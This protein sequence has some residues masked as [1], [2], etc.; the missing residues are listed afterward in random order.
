MTLKHAI[1]DSGKD[2]TWRDLG[3]LFA[4]VSFSVTVI[5]RHGLEKLPEFA[6]NPIEF[7]DPIGLG[8]TL[9]LI[10]ATFAELVCALA[11][12]VGIASRPASALLAINFAVIVVA[13]H[14][15]QVP[16]DRGEL[17]FLFLLAFVTLWLTGPGRYSLDHRLGRNDRR[18]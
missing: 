12:A 13:L 9:S 7:F 1:F 16:G 3:L 15:G 18:R 10:L 17:A 6:A 5:W 14:G 2:G 11:L 4:R 8:P